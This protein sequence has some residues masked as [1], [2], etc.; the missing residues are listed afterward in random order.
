[1]TQA[2]DGRSRTDVAETLRRIRGK[3]VR[4]W[5]DNGELHYRAPKGALAPEEIQELRVLSGELVSLLEGATAHG[6]LLPPLAPRKGSERVPLTFAQSS[7]WRSA[8]LAE[9]P[10][11]RSVAAAR[12]VSGRLDVG[13]LRDCLNG[14]VRRHEALRTLVV[15]VDGV[16]EQRIVDS[17]C[18]LGR[19]ALPGLPDEGQDEAAERL[20]HEL[21]RAPVHV[22]TGPLLAVE[23]I[24][25]EQDRHVLVVM[26][27]HIVSDGFSLGVL[28]RDLIAAYTQRSQQLP[29][30]LPEI[31]V[32]FADY[33]V[34]QSKAHECWL[35]SCGAAWLRRFAGCARLKLP[36]RY[37]PGR[38]E[39][40]ARGL[41]LMPLSIDAD[42]RSALSAW[43][44]GRGTTLVMAVFTAFAALV[45]RSC[46]AREGVIPLQSDG[47]FSPLVE[48]S[49][50]YFACLL[51]MRLELR[52]RES[53]VDLLAR[54]MHEYC[55]A[56][57]CADLAYVGPDEP[58]FARNC[59]F[60]WI[61]QLLDLAPD[62]S[63][64]RQA[65]DFRP[66]CFTLPEDDRIEYAQD[67]D[68][69]ITLFDD[70]ATLH[71]H[72]IY[73]P[74]R[75][76][77]RTIAAFRDNFLTLVRALLAD[78]GQRVCQVRLREP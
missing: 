58:V 5:S 20:I 53:F 47:R 38:S 45:L 8:R 34:W 50:G 44:R 73:S 42:T 2:N 12:K 21:I 62:A 13:L 18:A 3:R 49:I 29:L 11:L 40:I 59:G 43:C 36:E 31:P 16:P 9:R 64:G 57:E 70:G 10:T 24:T 76:S 23:L 60:N 67:F 25:F 74:G 78:P 69:S 52:E 46:E 30:S 14:L 54:T 1:M 15:A 17:S 66:F 48:H 32:Q 63:R 68:P 75:N 72:V 28:W 61:P 41:L 77:E 26:M 6:G 55:A 7:Y 27:E 65:V 56:V 19:H 4:L 71:G 39:G 35:E 51:Y 37:A 22:D 33:A